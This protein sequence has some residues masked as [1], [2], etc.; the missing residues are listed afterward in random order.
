MCD[1]NGQAGKFGKHLIFNV[2]N[3]IDYNDGINIINKIVKEID[4]TPIHDLIINY[5][6][7]TNFDLVQLIAESHISIHRLNNKIIVDVFSCKNFDETKVVQL[8]E[9]KISNIKLINR[10]IYYK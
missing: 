4:M 9:N 7:D 2:S 10:G 6:N 5:K 3:L 1:K 8:F